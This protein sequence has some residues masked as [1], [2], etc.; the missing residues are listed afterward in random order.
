MAMKL[1]GLLFDKDATLLDFEKTWGAWCLGFLNKLSEGDDALLRRLAG[2]IHFD[3]ERT[4]F[5]ASS[6][7]IAGTPE[8]GVELLLPL[9]PHWDRDALLDYSN[10]TAAQADPVAITPLAPLLTELKPRKLGIATNDSERAARR[11]MAALGV[12]RQ[13]DVILGSDSGYDGKPGPGMCL[14][15][16]QK[17]SLEPSTVAM[18]GDSTHD[19]LAGRAAGMVCVGVTTGFAS[20]ADLAPY[21]DAVLPNVMALADW[22]ERRETYHA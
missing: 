17:L 5:R 21:A 13:F 4:T 14:A 7:V 20:Q 18:I 6:P 1:S 11:H 10:Q 19:L 15:F 12:E 3:L 16:A 9:L 2:T 22:L 8:E